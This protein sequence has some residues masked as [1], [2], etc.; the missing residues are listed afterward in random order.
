MLGGEPTGPIEFDVLCRRQG[1][2]HLLLTSAILAT[3]KS[4]ISTSSN[5][6]LNWQQLLVGTACSS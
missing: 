3:C 6:H 1:D 2:L 5:N 4:A